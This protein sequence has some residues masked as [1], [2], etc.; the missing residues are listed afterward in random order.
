[1]DVSV[2][3]SRREAVHVRILSVSCAFLSFLVL[4]PLF[5]FCNV[6]LHPDIADVPLAGDNRCMSS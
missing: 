3:V 5:V 4:L 2:S 6:Q 1:M